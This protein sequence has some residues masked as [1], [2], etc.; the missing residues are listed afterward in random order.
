MGDAATAE[1][2][3]IE[4]ERT[5]QFWNHQARDMNKNLLYRWNAAMK[6]LKKEG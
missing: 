4:L 6:G 2:L 1:R 3:N 5:M